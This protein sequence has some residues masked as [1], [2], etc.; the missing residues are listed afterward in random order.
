VARQLLEAQMNAANEFLIEHSWYFFAPIWGNNTWHSLD[1]D[2]L[3]RLDPG[4]RIDTLMNRYIRALGN[5]TFV[6]ITVDEVLNNF[7]HSLNNFEMRANFM[8]VSFLAAIAH[9][10]CTALSNITPAPPVL[11][12]FSEQLNNQAD[13][14][15]TGFL[16]GVHSNAQQA[17]ND[18]RELYQRAVSGRRPTAVINMRREDYQAA[19]QAYIAASNILGVTPT[20]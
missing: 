15:V 7:W 3:S 16:E 8:N 6:G 1:Q 18:A 19:Q 2:L 4:S 17:R 12:E 10:T 11:T 5:T 14:A 13:S 20:P 9:A